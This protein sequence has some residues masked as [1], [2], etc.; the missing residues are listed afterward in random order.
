[1]VDRCGAL[2]DEIKNLINDT[3]LSI[4]IKNSGI[5]KINSN[6]HKSSFLLSA[7]INKGVFD[8]ILTLVTKEPN[9]YNINKEN[10]LIFNLDEPCASVRRNK[11]TNL[12]HEII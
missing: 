5:I 10:K 3:K 6:P 9:I 4:I 8:K 1:L 2:T 11:I 7:K 12:V